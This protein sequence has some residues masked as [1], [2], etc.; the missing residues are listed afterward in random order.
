MYLNSDS[1]APESGTG[2]RAA[3]INYFLEHVATIHGES[4]SHLLVSLSWFR[5]HPKIM[6]FGKPVT[7]WYHDLFEPH[8]SHSLV[9]VKFIN[10]RAIALI[11]ELD[12]S[13]Q[14]V[15]PCLDF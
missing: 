12:E 10:S 2:H 8:V 15:V 13:V 6:D 9:P 14:F 3:R 4:R 11:D 5:Y 7:V 1:T